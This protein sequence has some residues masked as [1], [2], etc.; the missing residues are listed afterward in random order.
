MSKPESL[1]TKAAPASDHE[2]AAEVHDI[3]RRGVIAEWTVTIILLLFGTTTLVQA[4]VIPTG[5]MEESLLIGDHLLVDKL[6]YSPSG[7][8]SQYLLPYQDVQRQDIIVFRYPVDL[9]QTFVKRVVGVPGDRVRIFNKHLFVNGEMGRRAVRRTQ[10]QSHRQL[11]RQFPV[12]SQ[13]AGLRAGARYA[14]KPC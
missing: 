9:S 14:G 2:P 10:D 1:Q 5:S 4:F 13:H 3:P 12:E 7:S 8:I 11:S 6:A